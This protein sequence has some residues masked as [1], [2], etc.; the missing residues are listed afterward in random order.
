MSTLNISTQT[1]ALPRLPVFERMVLGWRLVWS[2]FHP[3]YWQLLVARRETLKPSPEGIKYYSLVIINLNKCSH[4]YN[5]IT[6]SFNE[7]TVL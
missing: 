7:N 1:G 3:V 4:E 5:A 6:H 2:H